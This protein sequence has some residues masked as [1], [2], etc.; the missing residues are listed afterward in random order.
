MKYSFLFIEAGDSDDI[1]TD[2]L[3]IGKLISTK[4]II[5]YSREEANVIKKVAEE[6]LNVEIKIIPHREK[7]DDKQLK[8]INKEV[9]I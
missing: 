4:P 2:Q 6:I 3:L 5:C 7:E 9:I 1:K 8:K